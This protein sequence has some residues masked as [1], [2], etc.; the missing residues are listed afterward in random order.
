MPRFRPDTITKIL[1]NPIHGV[2]R[3]RSRSEPDPQGV[4]SSMNILPYGPWDGFLRPTVRPDAIPYWSTKSGYPITGLQEY[5]YIAQ[6]GA[7]SL[8]ITIYDFNDSLFTGDV[9]LTAS[10][11]AFSGTGSVTFVYDFP[12]AF[13][14]TWNGTV[15]FQQNVNEAQ[16]LS[17]TF[18]TTDEA[19]SGNA[20]SWATLPT[21]P[22]SS[23]S[24]TF[25]TNSGIVTIASS[26][27]STYPLPPIS[28][29]WAVNVKYDPNTF[30][31]N[32]TM[33]ASGNVGVGIYAETTAEITVPS[34][35]QLQ[36]FTSGG[37]GTMTLT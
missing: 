15:T 13:N 16:T 33:R 3:S 23:Q 22:T 35:V 8:P 4:V 19:V 10:S 17:P 5:G 34:T 21:E 9:T 30:L 18:A 26:S 29:T 14:K 6:P 27:S 1:P 11:A 36:V 20:L 2:V 7:S 28:A 31:F 37:D 32:F 25:L 12:N 24:I